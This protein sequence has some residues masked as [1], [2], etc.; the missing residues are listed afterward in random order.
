MKFKY[1][2]VF[3]VFV[4]CLLPA[5]LRAQES[6]FNDAVTAIMR[7]APSDFRDVKGKQKNNSIFA[8]VWDCSIRVPGTIASRF[9]YSKGLYYEGALAQ[10]TDT[11]QIRKVYTEYA[12]KLDS[13][14]VPQRYQRNDFENFYPGLEHFPKAT[15]L[16]ERPK[17]PLEAL[18]HLALEVMYSKE[19][20]S[21]TAVMFI[22][23]H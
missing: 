15:W 21:F 22:Y 17:N 8:I 23:E 12:A 20:K 9:V 4:L 7:D 11:A 14:L 16:P 19:L 10:T 6:D 5:C 13:L 1:K 2:Q 3:K 18:P